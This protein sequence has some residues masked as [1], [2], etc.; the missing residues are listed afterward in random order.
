[1]TD[2]V[3]P[4]FGKARSIPEILDQARAEELNYIVVIGVTKKGENFLRISNNSSLKDISWAS[5][6][7]QE[8]TLRLIRED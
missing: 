4:I 3:I 6:L 5:T 8:A 1:M 2:N 7:L